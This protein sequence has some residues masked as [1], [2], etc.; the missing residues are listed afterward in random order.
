[1]GDGEAAMRT[2]AV[3]LTPCKQD[4]RFRMDAS[5]S[6]NRQQTHGLDES[7]VPCRCGR[8]AL[9]SCSRGCSR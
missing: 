9:R 7:R 1:M 8:P 4:V 5:M 3:A 2:L 6:A